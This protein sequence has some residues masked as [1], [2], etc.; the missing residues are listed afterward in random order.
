MGLIDVMPRSATAVALESVLACVISAEEFGEY[1][2]E[3]PAA[4]L[5]IM[6]N[7]SKRIRELTQDYLD[8]CRAVAEMVETE[9]NGKEKSGW[10]KKVVNKFVEDYKAT[11]TEA[12]EQNIIHYRHY[13][14][15]SNGRRYGIW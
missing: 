10:L 14:I 2:K 5:L 13:C 1:F 6:Q 3:N 15:D 4:V 12:S 7:M 9:K 8:A 11:A